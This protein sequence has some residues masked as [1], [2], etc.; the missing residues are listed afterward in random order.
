M[1]K[2]LLTLLVTA[3]LLLSAQ[4]QTVKA[5][6]SESGK[7]VKKDEADTS[8]KQWKKGGIYS[9]SVSQGTLNNWAAGGDDFSLS[10]NSMLSLFAFYKK[11]HHSWD[12]TFD[13][14]LGYVN[15]SSL[16]GRKNDDRFDLLSKYGHALNSKLSLAGIVN[17]RSQLF[18]G[19]TFDDN[20]KTFSSTF[21]APG[22][23][24]AGIGIDYKVTKNLSVFFSPIT[25]RWVIVKDTALS[26]KGLYGVEPGE[27]SALEFGAFAT[28]GYFKEFNKFITYKGRLDLF[29]NYRKKPQN[30]DLFMSNILNARIG[31]IFSVSWG[32]DMIYD[33]D[34]NLFGPNRSSPAL[35]LKSLV[36]LGLLLKF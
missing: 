22:Y 29:S 5:L 6:Q 13:F 31:K 16:G 19:Y 3:P 11:G 24:L 35:Q 25:A 34:V 4:D 21:L 26:N 10:V 30:I 23:L 28:I 12:N 32:V 36:G 18:R 14:N 15:T 2:I 1:K 17:L 8:N 27:K 9:I 20:I 7:T 33:D